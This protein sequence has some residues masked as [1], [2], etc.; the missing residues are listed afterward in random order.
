[1]K[2]LRDIFNQLLR[3]RAP[4]PNAPRIDFSYTVYWTKHVR[5]WDAARRAAVREALRHVLT[6]P[7]FE[8]NAYARRYTVPGLDAQAHSGAS[9]AA[10]KKVLAAFK[11][12]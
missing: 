7:G 11:N 4:R 1:M 5:Q 9:L 8:P 10:L 2:S 12:E 6:Q 3:P